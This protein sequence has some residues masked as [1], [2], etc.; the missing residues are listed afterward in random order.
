[1]FSDFMTIAL[2]VKIVIQICKF[3]ADVRIFEVQAC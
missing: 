3:L 2:A 1:M